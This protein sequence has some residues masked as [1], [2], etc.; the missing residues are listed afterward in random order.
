VSQRIVRS[1]SDVTNRFTHSARFTK[2][3]NGVFDD[4]DVDGSGSSLA[5]VCML[6]LY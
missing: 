1:T 5:V 6:P 3:V 2:L 4:V